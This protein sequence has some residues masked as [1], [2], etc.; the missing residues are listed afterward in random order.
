MNY[1]NIPLAFKLFDAQIVPKVL[2]GAHIWGVGAK[3]SIERIQ[4]SFIKKMFW[5]PPHTAGYILR[6]EFKRYQ[7]KVN[8][9]KRVI[10]FWT[11]I[12]RLPEDRLIKLCLLD[13]MKQ[14]DT[15]RVVT[16]I[17]D[18]TSMFKSIGMSLK[19]AFSL[20]LQNKLKVAQLVKLYGSTLYNEDLCRLRDT[21]S[22]AG[23]SNLYPLAHYNSFLLQ[24]ININFK[25]IALRIRL[26]CNIIYVND[27]K[28]EI[29]PANA[30]KWCDFDE[31]ED[32]AHALS[33]CRFLESI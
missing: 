33:R 3:D 30:C 16:W 15:P 11:K 32:W 25:R 17:R 26:E 27:V 4:T 2:F 6:L 13:V 7:I 1:I 9:F 14:T 28:I 29:D 10:R 23:L 24:P 19:L 22:Y 18:L 21:H 12:V 20:A 8:I 5:L 31:S